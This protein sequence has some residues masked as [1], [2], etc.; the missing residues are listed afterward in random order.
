MTRAELERLHEALIAEQRRWNEIRELAPGP[1]LREHA[2]ENAA[3]CAEAAAGG[4]V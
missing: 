2:V 1:L 4:V 3:L